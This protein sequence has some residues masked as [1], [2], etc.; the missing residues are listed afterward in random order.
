MKGIKI[1]KEEVKLSLFVDDMILSTENPKDSIRKLLELISEIAKLQNTKSIH[2]NYLHF[3]ILGA[4]L[5]AQLVKNLPTM[6]K[7]WVQFLGLE[8]LLVKET[9]THSS[10]LAWRIPWSLSGSSVH[11]VARVRH[12]LVTKLLLPL[13]TN[14][15]KS[16]RE[17]KISIPFTISTK[18]IKYL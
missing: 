8:E 7:T 1:R 4:S 18:T 5:V 2:I 15:E 16:E 6:L 10:I 17:S 9:A 12:D 11:G 14:N 3:Y 13:Y